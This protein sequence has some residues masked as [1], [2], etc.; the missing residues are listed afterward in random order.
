MTDL[1]AL[2]AAIFANV[3]DDTVRLIYADALEE[4]GDE[5]MA[6]FIRTMVNEATMEGDLWEYGIEKI[7]ITTKLDTGIAVRW[8]W[9][10]GESAADQSIRPIAVLVRGFIDSV[11]CTSAD[12][13]RAADAILARHP[14]RKV[15]L[16]TRP[17]ELDFAITNWTAEAY[18]K[19]RWP[20]VKEWELPPENQPEN[21]Y[22]SRVDDP[23]NFDYAPTLPTE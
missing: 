8:Q 1:D 15:R 16:T 23:N 19:G 13:T 2:L 22:M 21:W 7:R 6:E 12:W 18:L 17:R 9:A 14:V 5:F 11:I 10:W 20:Q 3:D 4:S